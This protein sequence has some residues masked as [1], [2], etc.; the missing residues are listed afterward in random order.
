[1]REA[2]HRAKNVLGLVQVIARQTAKG[3]AQDFIDRLTER[4]R[5]LASNQDLLVRHEWKRIDV[6]DLVH[7]QLRHFADLIGTRMNLC[8]SKLHLNAAAAQ[9]IGLAFHE[10]ATN[11]AKYGALST[12][13]G[14]V[15]IRWGV[16]G[17]TF[18]MSWAERGGPP[19]SAPQ[20]RGSGSTVVT[21]LVK[22]TI[23]G[24]V[25]LEYAPSGLIWRLI[26]P[27]RECVEPALSLPAARS[28]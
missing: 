2:R 4:I 23:N 14:R 9:A 13:M 19:V 27:H 11:A 1:M 15:D 16:D 18:T 26:C 3:T 6:R 10:L 28:E 25:Q 12:E 20:R 7:V 5:A 21:S 17:E 8:G 24:E 22:Q